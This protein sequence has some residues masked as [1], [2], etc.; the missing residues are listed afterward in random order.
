M[1]HDVTVAR[2]IDAGPEE[3][4]DAFT[5]PDGQ[6][7][8]YG[9]DDPGW[10]VRSQCDMRVGGAWTVDFGPSPGQLYRHRHVF[11]VIDRPRRLVLSTTETRLDGST[12]RFETEFTFET[13]GQKTLMTMTQRGPPNRPAPRRAPAR[14]SQRPHPLANAHPA[15]PEPDRSPTRPDAITTRRTPPPEPLQCRTICIRSR[16]RHHL[17][18]SKRTSPHQKRHATRGQHGSPSRRRPDRTRWPR[19]WRGAQPWARKSAGSALARTRASVVAG[20]TPAC[21]QTDVSVRRP[22]SRPGARG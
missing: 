22:R 13:R 7:A 16:S 3:V 19:S 18:R 21:L 17:V 9:Q 8:F 14:S 5:N 4:F 10:I 2:L 11:E 20:L 12:L 15:E 6:Q 1:S